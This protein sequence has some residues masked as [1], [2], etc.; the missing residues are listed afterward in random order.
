[1]YP[2][3][4]W[5]G[6]MLIALTILLLSFVLWERPVTHLQGA[7]NALVSRIEALP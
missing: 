5:L 1:M 2:A 7:P 3:L 4:I 6:I